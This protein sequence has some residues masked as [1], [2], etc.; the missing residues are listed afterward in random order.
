MFHQLFPN[1]FYDLLPSHM[2][3]VFSTPKSA[4]L[5]E[6][7]GYLFVHPDVYKEENAE[8]KIQAMWDFY[9]NVNIEDLEACE[10]VQL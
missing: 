1:V 6:E 4:G 7:K 3:M 10:E 5:T 8:E 9:D 2:Y